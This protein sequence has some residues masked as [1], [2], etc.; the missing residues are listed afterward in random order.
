V[1]EDDGSRIATVPEGS[2]RV[3][4]TSSSSQA[5]WSV[6]LY[7]EPLTS[8]PEAGLVSHDCQNN[9][10]TE[11]AGRDDRSKPVEPS[12]SATGFAVGDVVTVAAVSGKGTVRFL[13]STDFADGTWAGVEL[14]SRIG[15]HNG[16]VNGKTYFTCPTD[17]GFFVRPTN[18]KK[19]DHDSPKGPIAGNLDASPHR[20]LGTGGDCAS[21]GD[22]RT[23]TTSPSLPSSSTSPT[24]PAHIDFNLSPLKVRQAPGEYN[25][26]LG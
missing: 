5:K 18:L 15:K 25:G 9:Q 1:A 23:R 6:P 20:S 4:A 16:T 26:A 19:E 17:C 22:A 14:F 13:G 7:Q 11:D 21:D 12:R 10:H 8:S 3:T 2:D 24:M